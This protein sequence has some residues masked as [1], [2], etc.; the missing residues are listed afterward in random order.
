MLSLLLILISELANHPKAGYPPINKSH[1]YCSVRFL[2]VIWGMPMWLP[3][4]SALFNWLMWQKVI[5]LVVQALPFLGYLSLL[6][7]TIPPP[8]W[9]SRFAPSGLLLFDAWFLAISQQKAECLMICSRRVV[10]T[11]EKA[12]SSLHCSTSSRL[13]RLALMLVTSHPKFTSHSRV[14]DPVAK[15]NLQKVWTCYDLP[16]S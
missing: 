10:K 16:Y 4:S 13:F 3:V 2:F 5:I 15:S 12:R 8:E 6:D 14:C 9:H 11:Q 7:P 1:H